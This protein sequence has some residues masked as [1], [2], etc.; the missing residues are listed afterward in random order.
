MPVSESLNFMLK[1]VVES[2]M[3]P[4]AIRILCI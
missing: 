3:R 4:V 2:F 1:E